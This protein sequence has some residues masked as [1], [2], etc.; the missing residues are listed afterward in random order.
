MKRLSLQEHLVRGDGVAAVLVGG[1]MFA[2]L[3]K[4]LVVARSGVMG[5]RRG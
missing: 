3:T 1:P 5:V 2:F 4:P